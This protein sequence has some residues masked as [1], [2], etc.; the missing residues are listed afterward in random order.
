MSQPISEFD[1]P[2]PRRRT[3][4]QYVVL[5][6]FCLLVA[7]PIA[8]YGC[9]GERAKWSAAKAMTMYARGD[10]EAAFKKLEEAV[11][12]SNY[13]PD[14]SAGFANLLAEN[15]RAQQGL[16]ICEKVLD[17]HRDPARTI[18]TLMTVANCE[19]HL[20][21]PKQALKTLKSVY[22]QLSPSLRTSD[23]SLNNLA[24]YRALAN[25]EL[26]RARTER[27]RE[28]YTFCLLQSIRRPGRHPQDC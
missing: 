19:Q 25:V 13:D 12:D 16:E 17:L 28:E 8:T 21:R 10:R 7:G 26:P 23:G 6:I 11:V 18:N 24:Y 9:R 2:R 27:F 15:G 3:F 22:D 20:N 1:A 4:T 5:G 14:L